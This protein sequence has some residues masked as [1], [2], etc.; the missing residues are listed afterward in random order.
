MMLMN[1]M[2][3]LMVECYKLPLCIT[4]QKKKAKKP[5]T[6]NNRMYIDVQWRQKDCKTAQ[7]ESIEWLGRAAKRVDRSKVRPVILKDA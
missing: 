4:W 7:N 5:P 1:E 6:K 3:G 2:K